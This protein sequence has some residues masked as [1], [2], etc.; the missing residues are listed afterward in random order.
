MLHNKIGACTSEQTHYDT[1][2]HADQKTCQNSYVT[3]NLFILFFSGI[4]TKAPWIA[5]RNA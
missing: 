5:L 4:R 3:E 2:N 1:K